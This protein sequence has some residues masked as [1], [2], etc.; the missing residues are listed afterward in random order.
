MNPLNKL[1]C[2]LLSGLPNEMDLGM[3]IATMF[4]SS[5]EVDW[6]A[7]F[8]FVDVLVRCCSLYACCCDD[9]LHQKSESK[10]AATQPN[11]PFVIESNDDDE[12]DLDDN[13][14]DSILLFKQISTPVTTNNILQSDCSCLVRFWSKLCK[15]ARVMSAVFEQDFSDNIVE[16]SP[17]NQEDIYKQVLRVTE[18]IRVLSFNIERLSVDENSAPLSLIKLVALLLNCEDAVLNF[19]GLDIISNVAGFTVSFRDCG[20]YR[21]IQRHVVE[22]CL[23]LIVSSNDIHSLNRSLEVATKL[24]SNGNSEISRCFDS[25]DESLIPDSADSEMPSDK[26]ALQLYDRMLELLTC[27]HDVTLVISTLEFCLSL[28]MHRPKLLLRDDKNLI[29]K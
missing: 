8:K 24:T 14:L 27:Q 5:R 25:I 7:D 26:F 9:P 3:Q 17:Q 10:S 18:L 23:S 1:F 13:N 15:D 21:N 22:R 2:A 12:E 20:E 16:H 6:I 28:S 29:S 11:V 4:A 19:M